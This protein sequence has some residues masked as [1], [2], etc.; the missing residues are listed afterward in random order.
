MGWHVEVRFVTFENTIL[1]ITFNDVGML[2]LISVSR[3]SNN[4]L[5]NE[6]LIVVYCFF[7]FYKRKFVL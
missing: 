4:Y 6:K 2:M 7:F 5:K 1:N 3:I